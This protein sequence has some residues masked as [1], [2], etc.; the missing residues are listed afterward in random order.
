VSFAD[1]VGARSIAFI[2]YILLQCVQCLIRLLFNR[3]ERGVSEFNK[4]SKSSLSFFKIVVFAI[5][6]LLR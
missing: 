3:C 2:K 1:G 4:V 6:A 5:V